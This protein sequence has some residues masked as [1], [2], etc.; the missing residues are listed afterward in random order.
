MRL[1]QYTIEADEYEIPL[2]STQL[3]LSDLL[4]A[5]CEHHEWTILVGVDSPVTTT[6]VKKKFGETVGFWRKKPT[7]SIGRVR[8][9]V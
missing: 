5:V 1:A 6:M 3:H 7:V 8:A 2:L 4:L 9:S